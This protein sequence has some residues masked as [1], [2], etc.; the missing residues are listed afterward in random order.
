MIDNKQDQ[1]SQVSANNSR[2]A[3]VKN[4]IE[5]GLALGIE[6]ATFSG[7]E[8]GLFEGYL[9]DDVIFKYSVLD[10]F[11]WSYAVQDFLIKKIFINAKG[12]YIDVGANIGLI[13]IPVAEKGKIKCH[14]FEPEPNNYKVLCRNIL[15]HN[16]ESLIKTYAIA[17]F[18]KKTI[19]QFEVCSRNYGDHRVK[20]EQNS[21]LKEQYNEGDRQVINV[22]A[23][24]LD[25]VLDFKQLE[26][27]IVLKLD[28]QGSEVQFFR[29]AE[30]SL[31]LVDYLIVE[32][33]PYGI[34][35]SGDSLESFLEVIKQFPFAA[36]VGLVDRV[37]SITVELQPIEEII[38][39]IR[40]E[41]DLN[42]IDPDQEINL[43]CSR[44]PTFPIDIILN[45]VE[46]NQKKTS[47][48]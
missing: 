32:Y 6:T 3:L 38:K 41:V 5:S 14:V 42:N 36:Y 45:S 30:K 21:Q 1:Q 31:E 17:L 37:K 2:A 10:G 7:G 19:L 8:L 25:D 22:N 44:T 27:P 13:T 48:D 47:V 40:A 39:T 20:P 33:W 16:V 28:I 24:K 43:V 4:F 35:Y 34:L 11:P 29:G 23:E 26:S 9:K 46:E 15:A 18:S 12:T